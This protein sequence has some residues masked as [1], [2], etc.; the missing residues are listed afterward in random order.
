MS[1]RLAQL[2]EIKDRGGKGK[3]LELV[4]MEE[5]AAKE[6]KIKGLNNT[7][8]K[9]VI[10]VQSFYK[11]DTDSDMVTLMN[12]NTDHPSLGDVQKRR[13]YMYLTYPVEQK[14]VISLALA[15]YFSHDH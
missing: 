5:T 8:L 7:A 6:G 1:W 4:L 11:V 13:G 2:V 15:R 10:W 12:F 9:E 3:C 14:S